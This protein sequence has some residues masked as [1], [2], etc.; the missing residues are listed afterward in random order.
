MID[1]ELDIQGQI[2]RWYVQIHISNSH[3]SSG[4]SHNLCTPQSQAHNLWLVSILWYKQLVSMIKI[5]WGSS[6][7]TVTA[8]DQRLVC[9]LK[10]IYKTATQYWNQTWLCPWG[11]DAIFPSNSA[12]AFIIGHMLQYAMGE[13]SIRK[14]KKSQLLY[15]YRQNYTIDTSFWFFSR[16]GKPTR[17]TDTD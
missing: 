16:K 11:T 10:Y 8:H 12:A 17:L 1:Q 4:D 2:L 7:I 9:W 3:G 13:S 5:A 14:K 15:I 6:S